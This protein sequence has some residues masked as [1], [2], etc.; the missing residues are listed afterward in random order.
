M[1]K[2][3]FSKRLEPIRYPITEVAEVA[4]EY[5]KKG[6]KILYLN[7]G[8][9]VKAGGFTA[10][11]HVREAIHKALDDTE[12]LYWSYYGDARAAS[13]LKEAV[14]FYE[15]KYHGN[16]INPETVFS[17]L[18]SSEAHMYLNAALIDPGDEALIPSAWYLC[19]PN[20]VYL[21]NGKPVAYNL[22]EEENWKVDTDDIRK[23]ITPRTK[24]IMVCS[25]NNPTAAMI[26]KKNLQEVLD[27]AAEH[28]LIVIYDELYSEFVFEGEHY[29]AGELTKD[30]CVVGL[31]GLSKNWC[32]PGYRMGWIWIKDPT[33][34][35][36]NGLI[37]QIDKLT[38]T[39]LCANLLM[40]RAAIAALTG[41]MDH[42]REQVKEAAKRAMYA[43]KRIL[44]T[45]GL[46]AT[47]P[48]SNFHFFPKIER[49]GNLK[50]DWDFVLTLLKETGV[51]VTPGSAFGP[52]GKE[53]F[54]EVF[55]P[56]IE[57]LEEA[58]NLMEDFMR[59]LPG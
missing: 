10:P 47:K 14:A 46:S 23:K 15:K 22:I 31:G 11:P 59:K 51:L 13:E 17:F 33:E 21:F 20:Y 12:N 55:L 5:E 39:R 49:K 3:I 52:A 26:E 40:E 1:E 16:E 32:A 18:G 6:K 44:E 29:C 50:D 9:P 8:D 38:R 41:P 42:I 48:N 45:E 57:V 2:S 4:K 56:P 24:Y 30:T 34:K 19:Y 36:V 37:D 58:H 43:Y 28:N 53:H 35:F 7:I 25:P 54:R 27:I